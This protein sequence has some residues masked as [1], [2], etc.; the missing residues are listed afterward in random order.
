M[1]SRCIA[2]SNTSVL[3][4][5]YINMILS[6]LPRKNG[7]FRF[8]YEFYIFLFVILKL[9]VF[10]CGFFTKV[11]CAFLNLGKNIE[12][13]RNKHILTQKND[14]IVQI[15]VLR[16]TIMNLALLFLPRGWVT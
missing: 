8:K 12:I 1:Y 2:P 10:N 16:S 14:N 6:D 5:L 4:G 13:I 3:T 9:I 15:K 7:N 11:T